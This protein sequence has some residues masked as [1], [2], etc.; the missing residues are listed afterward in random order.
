MF[1]PPSVAMFAD[2][3]EIIPLTGVRAI[4]ALCI[5]VEHSVVWTASFK[6]PNIID[7]AGSLIGIYGMPLFFVLSGFVIHYNYGRLFHAARFPLAVGE[8]MAARFAR[9]YPL[10]FFFF[11]IGLSSDFTANW[12]NGHLHE[13]LKLFFAQLTLTQSWFYVI[14]V[15]DRVLL[16]NGFGLGWSISTEW[17]FYCVYTAMVFALFGLRSPRSTLIASGLFAAFAFGVLSLAQINMDSILAFAKAHLTNYVA[18]GA[19][20]FHFWFFYYSPYI[21]IFEFI[22][23]CLSAHL[24]MLVANQPIE[25]R[26]RRLGAIVL[27]LSL[28]ALTIFGYCYVTGGPTPLIAAYV[29]FFSLNFGCAVPIGALLFCVARYPSGVAKILSTKWLVGIG[30]ISYSIYAIHT[31]TLRPFIRPVVDYTSIFAIDAVIRIGLGVAFTII[32]ATATYRL[33][34]VPGRAFLRGQSK[35][36]LVYLFEPRERKIDKIELQV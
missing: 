14:V 28:L 4:A 7:S 19:S 3:R 20:S 31:W 30:E 29:R 36:A 24:F 34:E 33:I 12:T 26:E 32:L 21:R 23:G 35:K 15:N 22:I 9:L 2:R 6:T 5:L 16:A 18:E 8:F 27:W 11:L 25:A 1:H 10:F 17:F 13:L